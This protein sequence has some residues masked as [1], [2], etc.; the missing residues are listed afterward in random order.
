[1]ID[2]RKPF[3]EYQLGLIE[4]TVKLAG[5]LMVA[6]L[7]TAWT[8]KADTLR[9]ML[10]SDLVAFG[11]KDSKPAISDYLKALKAR[12]TNNTPE[13]LEK[14]QTA[15]DALAVALQKTLERGGKPVVSQ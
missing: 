1:L 8:V 14:L 7:D 2:A 4:Q 15:T 9:M 10:Y 13:S 11:I 12:G 6:P 3:L 5:T